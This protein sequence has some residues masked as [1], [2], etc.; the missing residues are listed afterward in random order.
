MQVKLPWPPSVNNYWHKSR[1]GGMHIS[2]AGK[3]F[4]NEARIRIWKQGAEADRP[5]GRLC[6][7][8][9]AFPPDR[10]PRDLDN[11]L[12]A[13]LDSLHHGGAI[14]D[15]ADIDRLVVE[16]CETDPEKEGY[17]V[18]TVSELA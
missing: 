1:F 7:A 10:R 16:R 18:V 9:N 3:A 6:V 11:I 13:L 17:V 2:T 4:R 5:T 8:I 12:K 14:R 15:D